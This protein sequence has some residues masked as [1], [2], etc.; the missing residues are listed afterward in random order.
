MAPIWVSKH[1]VESKRTPRLL[2]SF[3]LRADISNERGEFIK[4]CLPLPTN[5]TSVLSGFTFNM[6]LDILVLISERQSG[7][8]EL[9]LL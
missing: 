1:S 5:I 4:M 9:V 3:K 8:L 2:A 7:S 6:V